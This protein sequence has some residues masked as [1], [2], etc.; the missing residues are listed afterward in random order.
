MLNVLNQYALVVQAISTV[1]LV[2]VTAF[3]AWQTYQTVK[4]MKL[5]NRPYMNFS[6]LPKEKILRMIIQN[7]GNRIAE[8]VK[9][10][11][12]PPLK[13]EV[14][15]ETFLRDK[16]SYPSFPPNY[17]FEMDFDI[18]LPNNGNNQMIP[19]KYIVNI[20]YSFESNKYNE[21]YEIDFSMFKNKIYF[22]ER[23]M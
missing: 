19:T 16:L 4:T 9:I 15:N 14:V 2:L 21:K 20:I 1:I 11:I 13:S 8:D 12:D 18:V 10:F 5:S 6:I 17:K 7:I 3:Y 23:D 22:R